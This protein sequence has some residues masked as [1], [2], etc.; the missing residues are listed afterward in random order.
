MS[1]IRSVV[2][3][4]PWQKK[5]T[6]KLSCCEQCGARTV[7]LYYAL[8]RCVGEAARW[9]CGFCKKGEVPA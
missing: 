6:K 8:G 7:K 5:L 3:A 9:V 1:D 2:P 4:L